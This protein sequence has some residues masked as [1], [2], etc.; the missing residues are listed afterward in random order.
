MEANILTKA[1]ETFSGLAVNAIDASVS[2]A[3][4][5]V[6]PHIARVDA[7]VDDLAKVKAQSDGKLS[8]FRPPAG[9]CAHTDGCVFLAFLSLAIEESCRYQLQLRS[10]SKFNNFMPARAKLLTKC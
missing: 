3:M 8:C 10:P 1:T 4:N 7:V 2:S 6:Q 5:Q 9:E